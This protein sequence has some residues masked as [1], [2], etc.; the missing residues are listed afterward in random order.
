MFRFVRFDVVIFIQFKFSSPFVCTLY[1]ADESAGTPKAREPKAAKVPA[2]K[3]TPQASSSSTSSKDATS[4][5]RA[6]SLSDLNKPAV[7]RRL[8]PAPPANGRPTHQQTVALKT[9]Q[10]LSLKLHDMT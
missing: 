2:E 1:P 3:V 9:S 10:K 4:L 8:L 6:C 5:R 7:P